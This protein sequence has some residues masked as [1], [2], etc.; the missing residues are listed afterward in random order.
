MFLNIVTIAD[1][2]SAESVLCLETSECSDRAVVQAVC[3]GSFTAEVR[4]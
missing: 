2:H 4:A 1:G 3:R